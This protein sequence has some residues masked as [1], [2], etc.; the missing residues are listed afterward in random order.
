MSLFKDGAMRKPEKA[1]LRNLLLLKENIHDHSTQKV[2]D[3]GA[4]LHHI[5]WPL[6][7]TYRGLLSHYVETVRKNHG[8]CHIVFDGYGIPSVKD[9]E[10]LRRSVKQ[11]SRDIKFSLEMKVSVKKEEFLSNKNNKTLFIKELSDM[12]EKDGQEVTISEADADTDI[13]CVALQVKTKKE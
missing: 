5:H 6:N 3:G 2:I 1:S 13:V 11:K 9:H 10:H 12:L 8:K 4:L 7:L